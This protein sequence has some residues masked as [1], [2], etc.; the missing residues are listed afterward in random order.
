MLLTVRPMLLRSP[1]ISMHSI[2]VRMLFFCLARFTFDF[3]GKRTKQKTDKELKKE[4]HGIH[5][6]HNTK[7]LTYQVNEKDFFFFKQYPIIVYY[8]LYI[9]SGKEY[10]GEFCPS[11]VMELAFATH[12][13]RSLGETDQELDPGESSFIL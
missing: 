11:G 7:S 6:V 2:W 9:R 1:A 12:L 5:I 3:N 13:L 10:S 8:Y 4:M